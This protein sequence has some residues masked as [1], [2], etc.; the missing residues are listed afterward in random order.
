[1]RRLLILSGC[2]AVLAA[3]SG[4]SDK[5]QDPTAAAPGPATDVRGTTGTT[6]PDG[7]GKP[8]TTSPTAPPDT[9]GD[10]PPAPQT[11]TP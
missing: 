9:A 4:E 3:C 10:T 1:M 2:L 5:S 8:G 6:P 11:S 7:A